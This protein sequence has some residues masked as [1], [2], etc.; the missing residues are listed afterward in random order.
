MY[1]GEELDL[2]KFEILDDDESADIYQQL[3][4]KD[5]YL[6]L[7]AEA[8]KTLLNKNRALESTIEYLNAEMMHKAEVSNNIWV[9]VLLPC[10]SVFVDGHFI[11]TFALIAGKVDGKPRDRAQYC[12]SERLCILWDCKT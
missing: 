7:A 5:K 2:S 11:Q 1:N 10:T 3:A 9:T 4:K 12:L 6:A 8:G